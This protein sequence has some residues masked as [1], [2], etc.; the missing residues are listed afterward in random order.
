MADNESTSTT[1]PAVAE[2]VVEAQPVEH[3]VPAA[4]DASLLDV[5]TG[6][7]ADDAEL[8]AEPT[9]VEQKPA[10]TDPGRTFEPLGTITSRP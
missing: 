7:D 9:T 2:P 1:A 4:D 5:L 6:L 10:D 8:A 3:A